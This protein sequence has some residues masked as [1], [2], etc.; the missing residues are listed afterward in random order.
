M[1]KNFKKSFKCPHCGKTFD[2]KLADYM[3]F[4]SASEHGEDGMGIE[5]EYRVD[6]TEDCPLCKKEISITGFLYEYPE[7]AYNYDNL[8]IEKR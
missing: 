6:H 8:K 1:L 3:E 4:S 7:G 5:N 2:L